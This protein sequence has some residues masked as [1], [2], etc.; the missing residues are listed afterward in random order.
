MESNRYIAIA[1]K[2]YTIEGDK[3]K[4]IEETK[5]GR[6]FTFIS[7]LGI[8]I[9]SLEK[10]TAGLKKG[11]KFEIK[12]AYKDAYGEHFDEYVVDL[13]KHIFQYE[14][15][16]DA[17]EVREGNYI[18]LED[19]EGRHLDCT[20]VKVKKDVVVIDMNHPLAGRDLSFTGEV[21]ENR[22]ATRKEIQSKINALV[23]KDCG[24]G[25]DDHGCSCGG[26]SH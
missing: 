25:C 26:H 13:P 15:K 16:F 11:D 23:G 24:G 20:V 8:T 2:L 6:P 4:F 9:E 19:S 1:Y 10:L 12:V 18:Q 3:R 14:G 5:P 21:I 7:G 22:P 17:E